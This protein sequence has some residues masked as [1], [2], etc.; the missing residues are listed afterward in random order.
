MAKMNI[1][2][3]ITLPSYQ[4]TNKKCIDSIIVLMLFYKDAFVNLVKKSEH[5]KKRKT[6]SSAFKKRRAFLKTRSAVVYTHSHLY[7]MIHT[8]NLSFAQNHRRQQKTTPYENQQ[9]R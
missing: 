6:S 5:L 8:Q 1:Y 3:F 7:S 2:A 4:Q 9:T